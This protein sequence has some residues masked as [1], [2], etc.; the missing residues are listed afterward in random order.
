MLADTLEMA[1][2]AEA[3]MFVVRA[4]VTNEKELRIIDVVAKNERLPKPF[5]VL[6]G[7]SK[8]KIKH[9]S[10]LLGHKVVQPTQNGHVNN[11]KNNVL[12]G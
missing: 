1:D 4:G 2:L 3:T 7:V 10:F 9:N 6:N 12:Y 5:I 8:S 11:Y